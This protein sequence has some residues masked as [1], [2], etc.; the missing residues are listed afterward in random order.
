[1]VSVYSLP[2]DVIYAIFQYISD[3]QDYSSLI[4]VN[5]A[6]LSLARP[7]LY[8]RVYIGRT[9]AKRWKEIQSPLETLRNHPDLCPCVQSLH[10]DCAPSEVKRQLADFLSLLAAVIPLLSQLKSFSYLDAASSSMHEF[11]LVLAAI[12]IHSQLKELMLISANVNATQMDML[13]RVGHGPQEEDVNTTEGLQKLGLKLPSGAVTRLLEPW[14]ELNKLTLTSLTLSG[15]DGLTSASCQQIFGHIPL[16]TDLKLIRCSGVGHWSLLS[17]LEM[18]PRLRSLSFDILTF[19]KPVDICYYCMSLEH[20]SINILNTSGPSLTASNLQETIIGVCRFFSASTLG[21]FTLAST[22]EQTLSPLIPEIV[23]SYLKAVRKLNLVG[24]ILSPKELSTIC[25]Q[26]P[27]MEQL[28]FGFHRVMKSARNPFVIA[29]ANSTSLRTLIDTYS[30]KTDRRSL[31]DKA[32]L[33]M[34]EVGRIFAAI[35]NLN[36]LVNANRSWTVFSEGLNA[37]PEYAPTSIHRFIDPLDAYLD[38]MDIQAVKAAHPSSFGIE[39]KWK[40]SKEVMECIKSVLSIG[41]KANSLPTARHWAVDEQ[42]TIFEFLEPTILTRR[43]REETPLQED[44]KSREPHPDATSRTSR[45]SLTTQTGNIKDRI[46]P[47]SVENLGFTLKPVPVE[48]PLSVD[49]NILEHLIVPKI[50]VPREHAQ[51]VYA[52]IKGMPFASSVSQAIRPSDTVFRMELPNLPLPHTSNPLMSPPLFPRS[53]RYSPT[54]KATL[55]HHINDIG[56]LITPATLPPEL[57]DK[58]YD[59]ESME[60]MRLLE[61]WQE[62]IPVDFSTPTLTAD[63]S[64]ESES[65]GEDDLVVQI[66]QLMA[67]SSPPIN[68]KS[69]KMLFQ[70][71]MEGVLFPKSEQLPQSRGYIPPAQ[72]EEASF[73]DTIK[74]QLASYSGPEVIAT[75]IGTH[76]TFNGQLNSSQLA[77][78][79]DEPGPGQAPRIPLTGGS[80]DLEMLLDQVCREVEGLDQ[81]TPITQESIDGRMGT[82]LPVPHLPSVNETLDGHYTCPMALDDLTK[83]FKFSDTLQPPAGEYF[84]IVLKESSEPHILSYPVNDTVLVQKAEMLASLN[85]ELSWRPFIYRGEPISDETLCMVHSNPFGDVATS[86]T[87]SPLG[88]D[89]I[90]LC[91]FPSSGEGTL[92]TSDVFLGQMV[93][94][95][96]SF[97][98]EVRTNSYRSNIRKYVSSAWLNWS[99]DGE[100]LVPRSEMQASEV[101]IRYGSYEF[102]TNDQF[103]GLWSSQEAKIGTILFLS[104]G[105]QAEIRS[106]SDPF[107]SQ[108]EQQIMG[109]KK[110]MADHSLHEPAPYR[111]P[112]EHKSRPPEVKGVPKGDDTSRTTPLVS[113]EPHLE[114]EFSA[115]LLSDSPLTRHDVLAESEPSTCQPSFHN[116]ARPY[117]EPNS[118]DLLVHFLQQRNMASVVASVHQPT[119]I[120]PSSRLNTIPLQEATEDPNSDS[121]LSPYTGGE[122]CSFPPDFS[123][124]II[125]IPEAWAR[126]G[127]DHHYICSINLLQRRALVH[128]LEQDCAVT[129]TETE[130]VQV[131]DLVVDSHSAVVL[132]TISDVV[133]ATISALVSSI[134]HLGYSFERIFVILEAFP[135]NRAEYSV[136]RLN[137]GIWGDLKLVTNHSIAS[138]IKF[139]KHLAISVALLG[140][141]Q[142]DFG[143]V[144]VE[145]VVARSVEESARFIRL[146]GDYAEVVVSELERQKLWGVRSWLETA[147]DD[148]ISLISQ[149]PGMNVFA[150]KAIASVIPL[151]HFLTMDLETKIHQFGALFGPSRLALF[152]N[153][154]GR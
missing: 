80:E 65:A 20:V 130:S 52:S 47:F 152:E 124:S 144:R 17:L 74:K 145:F 19:S 16:L 4:L 119:H 91:A 38:R 68:N 126:P 53:S 73:P 21:S 127:E 82:F 60:M 151:S 46:I 143:D 109:S 70:D 41:S 100:N 13:T 117:R 140:T 24:I 84:E 110:Y 36:T 106:I 50:S 40:T 128:Q 137:S 125:K 141:D 23:Q 97:R 99:G 25:L 27:Q 76:S 77:N 32:D 118:H 11:S 149:I 108:G 111:D 78:S 105:L 63:D 51:A 7:R 37:V 88:T 93:T 148:Q 18:L 33:T 75:E 107:D 69:L 22:Q 45:S 12:S 5:K 2:F 98:S 114:E 29:L 67:P 122:Q 15:V 102:T 30:L 115:V 48:E 58:L 138:C 142:L 14:I 154:Y 62:T 57:D 81:Y 6:F 96:N 104:K 123:S 150:A 39:E 34:Q 92:V 79:T 153:S 87:S 1:M 146:F 89:A 44:T 121:N 112:E 83:P 116:Q 28:A 129:L 72:K 42:H 66:D 103:S 139:K 134:G 61:G 64:R 31:K 147:D 26:C 85:L 54:I 59:P 49:E 55:P 132:V 131:P 3:Y 95:E 113:L 43:A 101:N 10:V 136:E 90:G 86:I 120:S 9:L 71:R 56:D 35:P 8:Q 94:S 133:P 135:I